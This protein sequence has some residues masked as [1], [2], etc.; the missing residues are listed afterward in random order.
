MRIDINDSGKQP[1]SN[2]VPPASRKVPT[3][4][5]DWFKSHTPFKRILEE[6]CELE[7]E[8]EDIPYQVFGNIWDTRRHYNIKLNYAMFQNNF[9]YIKQR[10][11]N[12]R[13]C[14]HN[15][16]IFDYVNKMGSSK[17]DVFFL[18]SEGCLSYD[19][20]SFSWDFCDN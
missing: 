17:K 20:A 15:K 14:K 2:Y 12:T 6:T 5:Y 13:I 7:I 18:I 1:N 4:D 8:K 9:E 11:L 19:S 16:D 10:I 3:Y